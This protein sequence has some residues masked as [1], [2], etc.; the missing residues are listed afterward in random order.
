MA[1]HCQ[2]EMKM[3]MRMRMKLAEIGFRRGGVSIKRECT[4]RM[5][6]SDPVSVL[7]QRGVCAMSL[8]V[9]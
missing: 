9:D 8:P 7:G 2:K 6:N 3:R 4:T 1:R 5:T